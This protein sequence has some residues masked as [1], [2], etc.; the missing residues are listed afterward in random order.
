MPDLNAEQFGNTQQEYH[1]PQTRRVAEEA[2]ARSPKMTATC[3]HEDALGYFAGTVCKN[4]AR[5][6]HKKAMGK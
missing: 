4:C 2:L 1:T 5:K 6:G 3:G